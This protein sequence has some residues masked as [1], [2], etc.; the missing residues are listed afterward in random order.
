MPVPVLAWLAVINV[1]TAAMYARSGHAV[2]VGRRKI[3]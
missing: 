3:G 2:S 1:F